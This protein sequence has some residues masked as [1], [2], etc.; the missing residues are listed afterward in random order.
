LR[1]DLHAPAPRDVRLGLRTLALLTVATALGAAIIVGGILALSAAGRLVY[2][3]SHSRP[4]AG[5]VTQIVASRSDG[6]Q[7]PA[8]EGH[9]DFVVDSAMPPGAPQSGSIRLPP[10]PYVP[11]TRAG[12]PTRFHVGDRLGLRLIKDRGAAVLIPWDQSPAVSLLSLTA[13]GVILIGLALLAVI[14]LWRVNFEQRRL[15]SH[16]VAVEGEV[17]GKRMDAAGGP[18]YYLKYSFRRVGAITTEERE[19]RC[20]AEQWRRLGVE[21]PVTVLIDPERPDQ[22]RLSEL[23]HVHE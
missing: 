8:Q 7:G 3:S 2:L 15:L 11:D 14:Q 1:I 6:P 20:T 12:A 13:F 4:L 17:T 9:V 5:H 10:Q 21:Y 18:R 22:P 19:E 16:G 23:I